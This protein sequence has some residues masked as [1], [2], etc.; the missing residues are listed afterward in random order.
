VPAI[1][2]WLHRVVNESIEPAILKL[3]SGPRWKWKALLVVLALSL[4]RA[5][6]SYD[7]LATAY[8]RGTWRKVM[9]K[10][11]YPLI[12]MARSFPDESHEAKL[13]FRVTVPLLAHVLH[14]RRNGML[15]LAAVA[16]ALLLYAVLGIAHRVTG[17]RKAALF[18][19]LATACAWPG[20]T[21][22]HELRGGYFDAVALCLLVLAMA[23][24]P[25]PLTA[26]AV[27]AAAFTDERALVACGLV[28]LFWVSESGLFARR[29]VAVLI[30]C[31]AYGAIR[32]WLTL[33]HSAI[34]STGG[35]GLS[36]FLHET[37]IIP[38]GIWTGL[39]GAWLLVV[40]GLTALL[41]QR[42]YG[43]AA[44]FSAATVATVGL[45]LLVLDVTR[46]MAF[47]LPAVFVGIGALRR[48][49]SVETVERL[50]IAAGAVSLLTPAYVVQGSW[51]LYW[52]YPLPVQLLRW[53]LA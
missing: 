20:E 28:F 34:V 32:L 17:S 12:D 35:V 27:C 14:L 38:L 23:D 48:S 9:V 40:C 15:V 11:D 5:F 19:C 10:V 49:E 53:L 24:L 44:A 37:N 36:I 16:G 39:G 45:A 31:G 3:L 46:S 47:C 18:I 7:G 4:L 2:Q 30:G 8:D 42:R 51:E 22:F 50:S 1:S 21:A 29:P 25:S 33:A 13:T 41:L 52:L 6:P 26:A 43:M